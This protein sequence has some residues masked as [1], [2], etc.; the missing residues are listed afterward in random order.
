MPLIQFNV[1]FRDYLCMLM[2][3]LVHTSGGRENRLFQEAHLAVVRI[4][5]SVAELLIFGIIYHLKS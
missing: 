5:S 4:A 2:I 3:I 1:Y